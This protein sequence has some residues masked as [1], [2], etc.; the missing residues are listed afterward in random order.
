MADRVIGVAIPIPDPYGAQL[1]R[2]RE[3]FGDPMAASIPTHITLLPPTPVADDALAEIEAHLRR[4]AEAALPYT[5]RL[6]G[7]ATFRPVSPVVFVALADGI[8]ACEEVERRV[9]SGP[10]ARA[11][12]FPYHP[13]VTVAH[14]LPAEVLDRAFKEL[15]DYDA[16]FQ[17]S[18]FSLYE[19]G[20]DG[21]WRPQLAFPFGT[22]GPVPY[23]ANTRPS[24]G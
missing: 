9:R 19:H 20:R 6:R 17:V 7:T 16:S 2:W 10:L 15:A 5:V 1:Q 21:V 11:L 3:S 22:G 13:H 14:D 18:G 23:P 8:G 4:V 24:R 12:A